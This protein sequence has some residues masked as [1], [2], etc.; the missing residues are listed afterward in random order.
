MSSNSNSNSNSIL[1]SSTL[2]R[3]GVCFSLFSSQEECYSHIVTH[4]PSTKIVNEDDPAIQ[5]ET[6]KEETSVSQP[7]AEAIQQEESIPNSDEGVDISGQVTLTE[8]DSQKFMVMLDAGIQNERDYVKQS[9]SEEAVNGDGNK[10]SEILTV[11]KNNAGEITSIEVGTVGEDAE[12]EVEMETPSQGGAADP[13]EVWVGKV[14]DMVHGRRLSQ[15]EDLDIADILINIKQEKVECEVPEEQAAIQILAENRAEAGVS[16]L[17]LLTSQITKSENVETASPM[18]AAV[19]SKGPSLKTKKKKKKKGCKIK[20]EASKVPVVRRKKNVVDEEEDIENTH[21]CKYCGKRYAILKSLKYHERTHDSENLLYCDICKKGFVKPS[22][23]ANHKKSHIAR[24]ER[25]KDE[26]TTYKCKYCEKE[27]RIEKSLKHHEK[28]HEV[29]HRHWCDICNKNFFKPSDLSRHKKV[30]EPLSK[31]YI[32]NKPFRDPS[33]LETHVRKHPELLLLENKAQQRVSKSSVLHC[34][35][36][37][38]RCISFSQLCNHVRT[39]T[40]V[41]PFS[42][43]ICGKTF[44]RVSNMRLHRKLHSGLKPF[45]CSKCKINFADWANRNRH[46]KKYH[47]SVDSGPVNYKPRASKVSIMKDLPP[48]PKF[49]VKRE[50]LVAEVLNAYEQLESHGEESSV[51]DLKG[52][53]KNLVQ[54]KTVE[55]IPQ[56]VQEMISFSDNLSGVPVKVVANSNVQIAPTT[57]EQVY[58]VFEDNPSVCYVLEYEGEKTTPKVEVSSIPCAS[59]SAEEVGNN[60]E[61][62]VNQSESVQLLPTMYDPGKETVEMVEDSTVEPV[63]DEEVDDDL[64]LNNVD[65]EVS[66]KSNNLVAKAPKVPHPVIKKEEVEKRFSCGVCGLRF[67]HRVTLR[68]HTKKHTKEGAIYCEICNAE[69]FRKSRLNVHMRDHTGERPYKCTECDKS[70][71]VSYDLTV[72]MRTHTGQGVIN[73]DHCG[74][75]FYTRRALNAHMRNQSNVKPFSCTRCGKLFKRSDQRRRHM[76]THTGSLPFKCHLCERSF[77]DSSNRKR[78]VIKAHGKAALETL[79]KDRV[80]LTKG[81][82]D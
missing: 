66:N 40:K 78:H 68:F 44:N 76:L 24:D 52:K 12:K 39:H 81:L 29:G 6:S 18:S 58:V 56:Q 26:T 41:R 54:C 65:S 77:G 64:S 67:K 75:V 43:D 27:Y 16:D 9:I 33:K 60:I 36:C 2:Y 21:A 82:E 74:K 31:C 5:E 63:D 11:K 28:V 73:C 48:P 71:K 45:E 13:V 51:V 23:L 47:D 46:M 4:E 35:Y 3:C 70:F 72:H 49:K 15:N 8:A 34:K 25:H 79:P 69:F 80:S 55:G 57:S 62:L 20:K 38:K 7:L 59:T 1:L 61:M 10:G 19:V 30:H 14:G 17:T 50:A 22:Q 37:Y 53:T 42:C 32:C